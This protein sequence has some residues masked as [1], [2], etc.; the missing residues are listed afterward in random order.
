MAGLTSVGPDVE[1]H[2]GDGFVI[3]T[4]A[5]D[6]SLVDMHDRRPLVFA[7]DAAREG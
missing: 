3:V 5:A 2:E 1:P 6:A 7:P 4:A